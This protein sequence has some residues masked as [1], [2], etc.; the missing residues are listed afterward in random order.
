MQWSASV[1]GAWLTTELALSRLTASSATSHMWGTHRGRVGGITARLRS[2]ET[3]SGSL[4][5]ILHTRVATLRG[6][7]HSLQAALA[8]T[9]WERAGAPRM[10]L[11]CGLLWA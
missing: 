7:D 1:H 5:S 4:A 11:E 2:T 8:T 3:R 10:D 6:V 9:C